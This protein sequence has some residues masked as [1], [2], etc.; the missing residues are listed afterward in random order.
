MG[1]R[2]G[3]ILRE[4]RGNMPVRALAAHA[5]ISPSYVTKLEKGV[6]LPTPET[7]ASIDQRLNAGGRLIDALDEDVTQGRDAEFCTLSSE[8]HHTHTLNQ[9][10][11]YR[12]SREQAT[13]RRRLLQIAAG[14]GALGP[15][16]A[17]RQLIDLSIP[18]SRSVEDWELACADHLHAIRN[19]PPAQAQH[20]L[21]IDLL[22]ALRQ[23]KQITAQFGPDHPQAGDMY[24]V[25][26][27]LSTLNANVLTRLGKYGE[28]LRWWSTARRQAD[29]SRDLHLQLGVR[30][31][32]A[33]IGLGSGQRA[34]ETVLRLVESADRIVHQAPHTYGAAL[35]DVVRARTLS[36]LGRHVEAGDVLDGIRDRLETGGLPV[37]IM[38]EYWR[39]G[40]LTYAQLWVSAGAGREEQTAEAHAR[41]LAISGD[42][43]YTANAQ[44][45][46]ALCLVVSGGVDRGVQ[47]ATAVLDGIEPTYRTNAIAQ[48]TRMVLRAVPLDQRDRPIVGDLRSLLTIEQG[49]S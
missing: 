21:H 8:M 20:D 16:E 29:V 47:Q 4:M 45:L 18:V 17:L 42:Y 30:A 14:L 41:V 7:A 12:A 48:T 5:H 11:L 46:T 32:E 13:E 1:T 26:A 37:S 40:Q 3:E 44:L 28:A 31:T 19:R 39:H 22:A 43:Q 10:D 35:I 49:K 34:P 25:L 15:A 38:P 36:M 33:G 24:R 6:K 23:A 2:F 9:R 27:A